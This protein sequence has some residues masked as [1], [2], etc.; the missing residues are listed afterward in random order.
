M[1]NN[2]R[3]WIFGISSPLNPSMNN[4]PGP[5]FG[6]LAPSLPQ[7][8]FDGFS[9]PVSKDESQAKDSHNKEV[10][11]AADVLNALETPGGKEILGWVDQEIKNSSLTPESLMEGMKVNDGMVA[12]Y[13]G[14]LGALRGLKAFF[15]KCDRLVTIEAQ[16]NAGKGEGTT[17]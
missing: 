13:A 9:A 4:K 10:L 6:S 16:A 15:A 2:L 17:T 11:R 14:M 12:Y 8:A 7:G 3:L 1:V 5:N